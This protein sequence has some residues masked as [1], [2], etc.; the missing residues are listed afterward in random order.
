M[1]ND[2]NIYKFTATILHCNYNTPD[3]KIYVVDVDNKKFPNIKRNS[4]KKFSILGEMPELF[5]GAEYEFTAIEQCNNYGISYKVLNVTRNAPSNEEET[6]D[7]LLEIL[8]ENQAN[9]I[10]ENYPNIISLVKNNTLD[11]IDFTKLKGIGEKNFEVI[12]KKIVENYCLMDL[13]VEFKNTLSLSMIRKI[14]Q[15]YSSIDLLKKKLK[16]EPYTTLTRIS[17]IGFKKADSIILELQKENIIDFGYDIKS[18]LDR[19]LSCVLYLLEENENNGHTKMNL[20]D[21]RK[22][23][24]NLVPLCSEHFTEAIKSN[25]IHYNKDT[26]DISLNRTYN[27]EFE[28]A[29]EIFKAL[30]NKKNL[31]NF[32]IDKYKKINDFELSKEQ[33]EIVKNV[34]KYQI[35]IL[36]GAAGCGKTA[37][38]QAIIKMLKDNNKS[39]RLFSPTGR[40]AKILSEYTKENASTIHR[41]LAYNPQG[42]EIS[43]LDENLNMKTYASNW[44]FNKYQKLSTDIV[45]I[46]EFSMVDVFLFKQV[47]E[48]VDLSKTK[49]LLIG[50]N[51]QLPSVSCGNLLHDFIESKVIPTVTLTKVFRYNEGGLMKVATD[52]RFSK[53]YLNND[54]KLK[55]TVFGDNKDYM[56]VDLPSESIPKNV[57]GLYKKLLQ[58][59]NTIENIQVLTAKNVGDCGTVV[60]N[61]MIQKIANKNY[62]SEINMKIGDTT[63]YIGDLVI[64]KANNYKAVLYKDE[65]SLDSQEIDFSDDSKKKT[66][67][68]ANG[69]NG[70][71]KNIENTYMIIDFNGM[72]VKYFKEDLKS[73]SL[74]YSIT[75]HKSQ[76]GSIDNVILATPQSHIFMLNNNLI[77]VGLTRMKKNCYHLGTLQSVNQAVYKKANLERHTY[78]QQLFN[79]IKIQ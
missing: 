19:C 58:N 3:F 61:N 49:L 13:V 62:G 76:G 20:V 12:K 73:I 59:G 18:S 4:Y 43:Y 66:V 24:I 8:T 6:Y 40:A 77:Y 9:T 35:N 21:L 2:E 45:I 7:F 74:G 36:N 57:V 28:I 70:I 31:W 22:E 68:I 54:M 23:C 30:K 65:S 55:A 50:D 51:S 44:G 75:I 16:L 38:T 41:G 10:I 53:V 79:K 26:L 34:C 11:T 48:A 56:F 27:A 71:I 46:D 64:Q 33:L 47:I 25:Y 14:Y 63:F 69:E 67:F 72:L 1:N 17:G 29:N 42:V 60:L 39:F 5:L 15:K 37:S 52:V 32:N 78:M